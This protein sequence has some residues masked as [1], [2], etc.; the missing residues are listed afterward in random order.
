MRDNEMFIWSGFLILLAAIVALW[1]ISGKRK[2]YFS[3]MSQR[4]L[5]VMEQ[6]KQIIY[7]LSL[8]IISA[9]VLLDALIMLG[10]ISSA[11][12]NNNDS[13]LRLDSISE[14]FEITRLDVAVA[15][16]GVL[17]AFLCFAGV[18][19]F[20]EMLLIQR[21]KNARRKLLLGELPEEE[22]G[23]NSV[24]APPPTTIPPKSVTES[25]EPATFAAVL[26]A[27]DLQLKQAVQAAEDLKSELHET[28]EKVIT[29]EI[30][31]QEK[32]SEITQIKE[33]K[34][35]FDDMISE[36]S[37][38]DEENDGKSLSLTD[39]VMVGD[40]IMGGVKIDKQINNDP[41]AIARAVIDAYR[42][43]KSDSD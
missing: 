28:K 30:E 23:W 7:S 36:S 25:N 22:D 4:E 35:H 1:Y 43:G 41:E 2:E 16:L 13:N 37:E 26:Q 15:Y 24:A 19:L 29:L 5:G 32:D 42:M 38:S 9:Y 40:S 27:M 10:G 11:V 20:N 3:I 14:M 31:V 34:S 8:V 39:S 18:A 12:I 17:I 6:S 21:M 33:S